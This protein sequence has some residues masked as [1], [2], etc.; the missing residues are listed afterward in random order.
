[1]NEPS[2][3]HPGIIAEINE[4]AALDQLDA[5]RTPAGDPESNPEGQTADQGPAPAGRP[6]L[7]SVVGACHYPENDLA[8]AARAARQ[9]Q[10]RIAAYGS[11]DMAA[12][13]TD[14]KV[15]VDGQE[16][17]AGWILVWLIPEFPAGG[18]GEAALQAAVNQWREGPANAASG[19]KEYC[20]GSAI[21]LLTA[22]GCTPQ[23]AQDRLCHALEALLQTKL[24]AA[25]AGGPAADPEPGTE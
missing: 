4:I 24:E 19:T 18:K 21:D 7:V 22:A 15:P 9:W 16:Q 12:V 25:A 1:M 20:I 3:L 8:A 13:L 2:P 6:G 17:K 10:D 23:Q 14:L 11:I 5:R